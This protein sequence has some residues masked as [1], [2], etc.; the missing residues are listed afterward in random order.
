MR[1]AVGRNMNGTL[2][3]SASEVNLFIHIHAVASVRSTHD[4]DAPIYV[5][6]AF[7]VFESQYKNSHSFKGRASRDE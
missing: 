4:N 7:L 5:Q 2:G 3:L 6:H 1:V